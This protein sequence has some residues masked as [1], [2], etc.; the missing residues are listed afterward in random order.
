MDINGHDFYTAQKNLNQKRKKKITFFFMSKTYRPIYLFL[1]C[2]IIVIVLHMLK[3]CFLI[4]I[5]FNL[6]VVSIF[7][8]V[9]KTPK[10]E[11]QMPMNIIRFIWAP[12]NLYNIFFKAQPSLDFSF[13]IIF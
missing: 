8:F 10:K 6:S 4:C 11:K 3:L 5:L 13:K 1:F 12:N 7:F 9:K 2:F